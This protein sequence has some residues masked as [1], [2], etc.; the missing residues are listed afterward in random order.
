MKIL[1]I[2]GGGREHALVWKIRQSPLVR[3]RDDVVCVPGNAGIAGEAVC[4]PPGPRGLD[5]AAALADLA[6]SLRADLTVVGPEAPLMAGLADEMRRRGLRVFGATRAAARLEW[7][8]VFAKEFMT[9]HGIPTAPFVVVQDM[10]AARAHLASREAIFPVVIKADGLAAGKG[11]AIARD[12]RE[13]EDAVQGMLSGEFGEAGR[14]VV[15]ERFLEGTEASFFVL[16]DGERAWPLGSCQDYKRVGD[17]DEGPNTGGMGAI[18]PSVDVDAGLE[19]EIMSRIVMPAIRGMASEGAPYRGVLY[20]GLMLVPGAGGAPSDPPVPVTLEFNARFGD[21]ET[22]VLLPRLQAD[23]VPLLADAAEGRLD[24]LPR[25]LFRREA[26]ACVVMAA[27]GYPGRPRT[28]DEVRGVET[29]ASLEGTQVFHAGTRVEPPE[30]KGARTVTS[31][32]RVL[33][34]SSLGEDLGAALRRAYD[35]VSRISFEGMHHRR[36]IGRD[37]LARAAARERQM[38]GRGGS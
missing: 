28:G 4:M 27:Q 19:Q 10:E 33:A 11:V 15:I 13:A 24:E 37:A 30:G 17:G 20:A 25:D 16:S 7:S 5:D 6:G 2:G 31:S 35:G 38:A 29:L 34:V 14:R 12:R 23:L 22:Q 9:R 3:K 1:V 32:G 36:D 21:P 18:S 26:A 8:K